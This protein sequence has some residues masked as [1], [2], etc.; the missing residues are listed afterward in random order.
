VR[1][2]LQAMSVVRPILI[3]V[4]I[5]NVAN[6]FGNLGLMYGRF[7]LPA[8]GVPGSAWSTTICRWL[9]LAAMI[10][11]ALPHLRAVWRSPFGDGKL[12][13]LAP[14]GRM[15]AIGVPI[16][17]QSGLEMW[18]FTAAG[19]LIG[20]MGALALSS[21]QIALNLASLSFMVPLGIGQAAAT[22]VGNAIGRADPDGARRAALVALAVGASVM[23]ISAALFFTAP[24]ELA[25]VYTDDAR[26][27]V[28][29]SELISIAALFQIFDGTQAVGC[30]ILRGAADTRAAAVINFVGYWILG[31]PIGWLLAFRLGLGP[32]GLWW[33]LTTGLAVVSLLLVAR[34]VRRFRAPLPSVVS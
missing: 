16:G 20:S 5:A 17:L 10:A 13:A 6:V 33:G 22:R 30:G 2:T 24:L 14:Y 25:H 7:G 1:Q 9:M 23:V 18:V 15:L 19:L 29:A 34:V 8:L 26:V 21:H 32:R 3:A 27:G 4:V 11:L 31:L 28:A 12:R